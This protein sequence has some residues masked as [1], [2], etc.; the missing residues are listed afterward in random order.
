MFL[1]DEPGYYENGAFGIRIENLVQVIEK[2]LKVDKF[3]KFKSFLLQNLNWKNHIKGSVKEC[4]LGYI[5]L[6]CIIN[7]DLMKNPSGGGSC[8]RIFA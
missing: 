7:A 3:K 8:N 5:A 4:I 2:K 1:S 6:H